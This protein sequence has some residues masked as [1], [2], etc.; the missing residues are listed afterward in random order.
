MKAYR[1]SVNLKLGLFGFA[2]LIAFASLWYSTQLVDR[3]KA[4]E[5]KVIE[6]WAAALEQIPKLPQSGASTPYPDD[7]R[8]IETVLSGVS[9][10]P[11]GNG[12]CFP[13][14]F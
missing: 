2:I 12:D 9:K 10:L 13:R 3:L 8:E 4:R 7:L 5:T 14:R 1:V 6:L 11:G